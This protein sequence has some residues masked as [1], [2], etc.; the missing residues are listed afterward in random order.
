MKKERDK[1][2]YVLFGNNAYL[3]STY[4]ATHFPNVSDDPEQKSKDNYNF[5]HSQL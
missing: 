5:Y 1:P 2:V 4:M 3:N